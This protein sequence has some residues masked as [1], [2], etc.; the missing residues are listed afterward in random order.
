M[1]ILDDG[2][3]ICDSSR[4]ALQAIDTSHT[5]SAKSVKII[6]CTGVQTTGGT[7]IETPGGQVQI[8]FRTPPGAGGFTKVGSATEVSITDATVLVDGTTLA[9]GDERCTNTAPF[10]SQLSECENDTVQDHAAAARVQN[11]SA[12]AQWALAFDNAQDGAEYEFEAI[13]DDRDE[14][15]TNI[16]YAATITTPAAA[17]ADDESTYLKVQTRTPTAPRPVPSGIAEPTLT[18]LGPPAP[19][20]IHP[21]LL[22]QT[23]AP[24][25]DPVPQPRFAEP[26]FIAL[27]PA[28]P[29]FI[30]PDLI[31]QG[32]ARPDAKL[33]GG[34]AEPTL[35]ALGPSAPEVEVP[36]PD[37]LIKGEVPQPDPVVPSQIAEPT[38]TVFGPPAPGFIHPDLLFQGRARP[39]PRLRGGI[40]EPTLTA[41]GPGAPEA[42]IPQADLV[43]Q[44]LSPAKR[45]ALVS[46]L[47][48]PPIIVPSPPAPGPIHPDLLFQ[49]QSW[50]EPRL[51]SQIVEPPIVVPSPPAP[52]LI[53]PDLLFQGRARPGPLLRS[54]I[55][56]PTFT[57][58]GPPAPGF[59]LPDRLIKG[60]TPTPDPRPQS[61]FAVPPFKLGPAA[62][63]IVQQLEY[64]LLAGTRTPPKEFIPS[65]TMLPTPAT[66]PVYQQRGIAW[67]Y[68]SSNWTTF[69][70]F[71]EVYIKATAGTVCARL[72]SL[73][74]GSVVSGSEITTTSTVYV[75]LRSPTLTTLVNGHEYVA[76]LGKAGADSG[77]CKG[78]KV[79]GITAAT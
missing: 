55:V 3:R 32:R 48:D 68:T 42:E 14:A 73:T 29:G 51:R 52:G 56:E 37:L 36:Q 61:A 44:G 62:P 72:E 71:F 23:R 26:P 78:A 35:T 39:D 19:G 54:R 20:F 63:K 50:A 22:A 41:I 7:R 79:L 65:S 60:L 12:E 21:N 17:S 58:L 31:F 75:R 70:L 4:I 59:V 8:G 40:A 38:F 2:S 53:H 9:G 74:D 57:A 27:G 25:P 16:V 43:V 24:Q 10:D 77:E 46:T 15:Q 13:F 47:I 34:I 49:G 64:H 66:Q 33:K 76:A 30:H 69:D 5:L 1:A 6:Y 11:E 28:A 18:A 67:L 45:A